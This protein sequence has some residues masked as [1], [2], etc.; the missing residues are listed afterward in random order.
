MFEMR[1]RNLLRNA[2]GSLAMGL[3]LAG[4][5]QP[6]PEVREITTRP[7]VTL[8]FVY[9]KAASPVASAV[10][11]QGGTGNIGIFPNGST[12]DTGLL[13]SGGQYFVQHGISVV[14]PDV[15]SGRRHLDDFRASVE[16]AQDNAALIDFLRQQSPVPVWAVGT[17]NGSLS[18]AA[19]STHLKEKGPDGLVLTSTVTR[20]GRTRSLAHR[21][22]DAPLQE[23]KVPV[24]L[25][26]HR[27][28]A[29]YVTPYDAMPALAAAFSASSKVALI[30]A[31]GGSSNGNP[32]H[33]GHHQ[34][35][36]IEGAVVK[37]MADWIK[38]A[39][40]APAK[41]PAAN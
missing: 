30:T 27:D 4:H 31:Q 1:L 38:A 16:H 18:A 28:D 8:R 22:Y 17:S 12:R 21:V 20:E 5:A 3:A 14:I 40:A 29:C 33:T 23:V 6:Q 39:G 15:P 24:L 13:V 9:L 26:H 32:C 36:G 35:L 10:L 34:F 11:F 7:G 19:A 41:Q 37:D 2:A 25:V